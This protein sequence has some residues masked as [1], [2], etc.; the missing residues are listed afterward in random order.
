MSRLPKTISVFDQALRLIQQHA[1]DGSNIEQILDA[2]PVSR[3]TLARH[4]L[5][6]LGRTPAQELTRIRIDHAKTLLTMTEHPVKHIAQQ[7]GFRKTS[8][9]SDFF[10][11][12]IGVS[13][14]A[15]R[16][17][18]TMGGTANVYL[19][20]SNSMDSQKRTIRPEPAKMLQRR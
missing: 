6:R 17:V 13:P 2:L 3:Q 20:Q 8:N 7:V 5:Q 4:F 9:F 10:R 16:S 11:N 12:Q 18:T 14:T 19:A 15:F 1:C